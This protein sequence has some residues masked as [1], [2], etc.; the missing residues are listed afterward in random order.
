LSFEGN[1]I[2]FIYSRFVF[3]YLPYKESTMDEI[4]RVL[5][6]G[7]KI[8][9][10]D[11]DGQ[12]QWY[13]PENEKL[14][15]FFSKGLEILSKT[16]FDANVGRKLFYLARKANFQVQ[17]YSCEPYHFYY[18]EIDGENYELWKLKLDIV[19]PKL[20]EAFGS[21]NITQNYID[22]FLSYLKNGETFYYSLLFTLIGFKE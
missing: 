16:G 21:L 2:D 13:Y 17:D 11:L 12:F 14:V 18:G 5:K 8:L 10:Q 20:I 6:P 15:E 4:K 3:E 7:G 19:K 22:S 9:I 1:S